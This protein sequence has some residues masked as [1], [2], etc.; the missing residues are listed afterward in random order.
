MHSR[1]LF[2]L[3]SHAQT[4]K[5]K[6]FPAANDESKISSL[7]S[8][9]APPSIHT[10]HTSAPIPI[11]SLILLLA[12]LSVVHSITVS[13]IKKSSPESVF[14]VKLL[15]VLSI[16]ISSTVIAFPTGNKS[17]PS[18]Q[19]GFVTQALFIAFAVNPTESTSPSQFETPIT[20]S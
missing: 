18:V 2:T 6:V 11:H 8:P 19:S 14:I 4:L 12:Q 13:L 1:L 10:S 20:S 5:L 9:Q 17:L 16:S 15:S 7:S 3:L